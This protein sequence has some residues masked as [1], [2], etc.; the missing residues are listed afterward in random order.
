MRRLLATF[1][2]A[3]AAAPL[4]ACV[5]GLP[6]GS[7]DESTDGPPPATGG[8]TGNVGGAGTGGAGPA[9]T[10]AGGTGPGP[11][12][13]GG[14]KGNGPP[15]PQILVPMLAALP[16]NIAADSGY[17]YWAHPTM[18]LRATPVGGGATLTVSTTIAADS[19]VAVSNGRIFWSAGS[20]ILTVASLGQPTDVL[21]SGQPSISQVAVNGAGVVWTTLAG[22]TMAMK[23]DPPGSSQLLL[24]SGP[25]LNAIAI[26]ASNVYWPEPE[27]SAIMKMPISGGGPAIPLAPSPAASPTGIAVDASNVY[28]TLSA[29]PV[30][31]VSVAGGIPEPAFADDGSDRTAT[32]IAADA[33]GVYYSDRKG[34]I[35]VF[36]ARSQGTERIVGDGTGPASAIAVDAKNVYWIAPEKFSI[37]MAPK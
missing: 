15:A 29:G 8:S 25:I 4:A 31:R 7:L 9:S 24:I 27:P 16:R 13:A 6:G 11:T 2:I 32:A 21:V 3:A 26:D 23:L 1:A 28:W 19:W 14:T 33:D 10:G 17:V 18:G 12:G 36:P 34:F 5:P 35:H 20:D 30:M 22:T 37:L